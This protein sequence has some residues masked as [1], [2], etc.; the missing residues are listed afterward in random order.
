MVGQ[1]IDTIY[2]IAKKSI[3]ENDSLDITDMSGKTLINLFRDND[4]NTPYDEWEDMYSLM[5][6][7]KEDGVFISETFEQAVGDLDSD[8]SDCNPLYPYTI[9]EPLMTVLNLVD[10]GYVTTTVYTCPEYAEDYEE[11]EKKLIIKLSDSRVFEIDENHNAMIYKEG[12]IDYSNRISIFGDK[13]KDELEGISKFKD[14]DFDIGQ[15][16]SLASP[17]LSFT[18]EEQRN[19][20]TLLS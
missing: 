5:V 4:K 3:L 17:Y 8:S 12:K 2:L 18:D 1:Q 10:I 14:Y 6:E 7:T 19:L 9:A 20:K 15:Y 13:T 11:S 16:L